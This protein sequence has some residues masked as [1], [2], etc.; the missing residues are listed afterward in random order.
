[1]SYKCIQSSRLI[2]RVLCC[3]HI[4][5]FQ[6]CLLCF[7]NPSN[8]TTEIKRILDRWA[9]NYYTKEQKCARNT[10]VDWCKVC[11]TKE[12]NKITLLDDSR[13][14]QL[15]SI[16]TCFV[17]W[18]TG[19]EGARVGVVSRQLCRHEPTPLVTCHNHV[20][21]LGGVVVA[22]AQL[23]CAWLKHIQH[24]HPASGWI[25]VFLP[26]SAPLLKM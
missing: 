24:L 15:I 6:I 9:L 2:L 8:N 21:V 14:K 3:Q 19:P 4:N 16:H 1:M 11:K 18:W 26:T 20:T 25:T 10:Y 7:P 13:K 12:G 23:E 22:V 5:H 17:L